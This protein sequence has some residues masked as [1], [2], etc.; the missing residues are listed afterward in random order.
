[1]TYVTVITQIF[2]IALETLLLLGRHVI[3]IFTKVT[4]PVWPILSPIIRKLF[5]PCN[6]L[7]KKIYTWG[8][9]RVEMIVCSQMEVT[10]L[11]YIPCG[12]LFHVP[13]IA[14]SPPPSP[15]H[16]SSYRHYLVT[17]LVWVKPET[18]LATSIKRLC[19]LFIIVYALCQ[20]LILICYK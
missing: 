6:K 15:A 19:N 17:L 11:V 18:V 20:Q 10:A 3:P 1:M 8:S 14:R 13:T 7:F 4:W 16:P 2:I 12:Q 9:I 5:C